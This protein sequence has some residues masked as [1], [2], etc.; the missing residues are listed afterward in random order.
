[1]KNILSVNKISLKPILVSLVI[2]FS[3][4]FS[5]TN[6][7]QA[8]LP[9]D[10]DD[11]EIEDWPGV[12][13]LNGDQVKQLFRPSGTVVYTEDQIKQ[14]FNDGVATDK[15]V[16]KETQIRNSVQEERKNCN[17]NSESNEKSATGSNHSSRAKYFIICPNVE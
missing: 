8:S 9:S 16:E 14:L 11:C 10:L 7:A 4:I 6:Y 15:D 17:S 12:V 2:L 13:Q 5:L 3:S 1:M